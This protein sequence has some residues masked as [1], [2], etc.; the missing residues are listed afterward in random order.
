MDAKPFRHS[1]YFN[2]FFP[3]RMSFAGNMKII[4]GFPYVH[5]TLSENFIKARY[6]F[7]KLH[8]SFFLQPNEISYFVWS[9]RTEVQKSI[10][11]NANA[12]CK[13]DLKSFIIPCE[14]VILP[15]TAHF[16]QFISLCTQPVANPSATFVQFTSG[17]N[18]LQPPWIGEICCLL[19]CYNSL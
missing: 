5:F 17:K 15:S 12:K 3:L 6:P 14:H 19:N 2:K 11:L 8:W 9:F 4:Q 7:L 18:R 10:N 1:F 16:I 13:L